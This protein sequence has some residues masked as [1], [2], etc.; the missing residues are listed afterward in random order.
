MKH[1]TLLMV[2][3]IAC[4]DDQESPCEYA[5]A[6]IHEMPEHERDD[7]VC[8]VYGGLEEPQAACEYFCEEAWE[9]KDGEVREGFLSEH[10]SYSQRSDPLD[11]ENREE[12]EAWAACVLVTDCGMLSGQSN[13]G[14]FC[15]PHM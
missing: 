2:L 11:P 1:Y 8:G 6:R 12:A 7:T 14:I 3:F 15:Q 4:G 9:E 10:G 13:Q 5:C